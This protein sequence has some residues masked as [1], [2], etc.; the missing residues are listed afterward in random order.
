[1]DDPV[2]VRED[3]TI[4]NGQPDLQHSV[5]GQTVF[6]S[7]LDE[8]LYI[9]ASHYG[10]DHVRLLAFHAHVIDGHDVGMV[11]NPADRLSLSGNSLH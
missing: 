7:I 10:L 9:P 11:T 3:Q 2:R 5:V 6:R 4:C 1:M 8:L